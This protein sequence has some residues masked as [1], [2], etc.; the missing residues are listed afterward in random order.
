MAS[1]PFNSSKGPIIGLKVVPADDHSG[2]FIPVIHVDNIDIAVG[3]PGPPGP[4]GPTGS[5]GPEGPPGEQ[6][7]LVVVAKTTNYT[8]QTNDVGK[9]FTN[10]PST[11]LISF[12]L[13][14]A[15][16]GLHYYFIGAQDS[17]G[18]GH[19][20]VPYGHSYY[21]N[22]FMGGVT[23]WPAPGSTISMGDLSS[24]DAGAVMSDTPFASLH[25]VALSSLKWVVCSMTGI[26]VVS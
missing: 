14:P 1:I 18:Y 5:P 21:G 22:T 10:S 16:V 11:S 19:V 8:L 2:D 23:I 13:P 12:T 26:W 20:P 24:L 7:P 15:S 3:P 9:V 6:A 25:V 17:V 4:Q